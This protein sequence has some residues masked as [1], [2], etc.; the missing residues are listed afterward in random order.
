MPLNLKFDFWFFPREAHQSSSTRLSR[1]VFFF[2]PMHSFQC[3]YSNFRWFEKCGHFCQ[4][5]VPRSTLGILFAF[6]D[7]SPVS[8]RAKQQRAKRSGS[9]FCIAR[10]MFLPLLLYS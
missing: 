1:A 4:R 10:F 7:F 9:E 3:F 6:L 2:V 8:S 5:T